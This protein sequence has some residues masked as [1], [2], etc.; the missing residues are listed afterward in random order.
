[1][2]GSPAITCTTP[3]NLFPEGFYDVIDNPNDDHSGFAACGDHTGGGNML[4]VNGSGTPNFDVWCQTVPV[5]PNTLYVFSAWVTTVVSSAPAVLQFSINGATIGPTFNAPNQNCIW[6]NYFRTWNSGPSTSATICIV[7]QNTAQSGNDF[8]LDDIVF[9]PTCSV[10]D[11]VTVNVVS[12]A[13][14]ASP[15]LVNIPCAGAQVTLNGNGSSAGP[16]V[17]Y[18][19]DTANGHIVSGETT[20]QPVV[21]EVGA[22][23]LHVY[24]ETPDGTICEKNVTVNVVPGPPFNTWINPPLPL[25]CGSPSV[26]LVGNASQLPNTTFQWSTFDGSIVSGDDTRFCTINQPGTYSVV[27]TNVVTGCTAEAQVEVFSNDNLPTAIASSSGTI[28]C[29]QNAVP[30][31]ALGSTTGPGISY[32]W[33]TLNGSIV[34]SPFGFNTT[35]GAAGTYILRVTNAANCSVTDTIVVA[36]NTTPPTVV[37]TFPPQLSC[38]PNQDTIS[39]LIYA[40]PPPFVLINWTTASGNIV[41]GQ[42]T[43]NPQVSQPGTYAVSVFDPNNGC[44]TYDTSL[45]NANFTIP[46]ASILPP[47]TVTCQSPT[48]ALSGNG[49]STGAGVIFQWQAS[50]GGNIVSGGNTLSPNVNAAGNYALIVTDSLSQCRDTAFVSV[51]ADTSVVSAVANAPDTLNC[52]TNSVIL[53]A[54]GSSAGTN[55]AYNWTTTNGTISAGANTANPT[56]S[57]PGTYQLLV[58]NTTNGCTATDLAIVAQNTNPPQF[59]IA[60]PPQITCANPTQTLSAQNNGPSGNYTYNWTASN[61]GN[62]V[63]GENTLTPLVS[64]AGIYTLSVTNLSDGC[65]ATVN[66]SVSAEAGLPSA[67]A[68]SPGPLTCTQTA[69]LLQSTG[70]SLGPNFTYQWSTLDG[71][72][73]QN[74]NSPSPTVTQAGSYNLLITNTL[75]GCSAADTVTVVQDIAPPIADAG[76]GDTLTC[77]QPN[78]NLLAIKNGPQDS[79]YFEWATIGGHYTSQPDAAFLVV[80]SAGLF[81]LEVTNLNNGCTATDTVEVWVNQQPPVLSVA[82]PMTLTCTTTAVTL[83]AAATGTDLSFDWETATGQ[84]VSGQATAAPTVNLPGNYALT[85]TD[86]TNGCS[87]TGGVIVFQNTIA[88][89]LSVVAP[90]NLNCNVVTQTIQAQNL[91]TAGNFNYTWTASNGGNI[92]SGSNTLSPIVSAGGDFSLLALNTI[93]GCRD[94]LSVSVAQDTLSPMADAGAS[95]TLDCNVN[96]LTING[97]GAGAP[98]LSFEWSAS[99]GGNITS[100]ANTLTPTVNASG[101]YTLTVSNPNNGCVAA[102]SVQIFANAAAPQASIAAPA[103]ITCLLPQTTLSASASSG[104]AFEY[105]WSAS[106]NGNIVSGQNTL[107][108]TVDSAG[109]YT[110]TVSNTANGCSTNAS[111]TANLALPNVSAGANQTITCSQSNIFL[112]GTASPGTT[113][114]W[115]TSDGNIV[116]GAAT[117][118]PLVNQPGIYTLSAALANNGCA[119]SDFVQIGI[120]TL[121]PTATVAMPDTLT[122]AVESVSLIAAVQQPNAAN[123]NI[124]WATNSGHFVS[125]QNTLNPVVDSIGY[126]FLTLTNTLNGCETEIEVPVNQNV[127]APVALAAPN[128][129]ITCTNLSATLSG[130]GSDAGNYAWAASNGGQ[131]ASGANTL[132]PSVTAAGLYTLTVTNPTNGCSAT[133]TATVSS[134]TAPPNAV[135]ATPETLTCTQ[136]IV[137]LN[138]SASSQGPGFNISWSTLDGHLLPIQNFLMPSADQPGT[139]VLSIQN[140]QNG[141]TQSAQVLVNQNTTPPS[142][143]AGPAQTLH[144][145]QPEAALLGSSNTPGNPTFA[146]ATS[147]GHIVGSAVGASP[148]VDAEGLYTLTVTHP[149][150]GCTATD[151]VRVRAVPPPAFLPTLRQ[152]DCLT[153]V[154]AVDFGEVLGGQSPFQY[155]TDGGVSFRTAPTFANLSPGD[156]ELVVRDAYGCTTLENATLDSPTLP[157]LSLPAV[158]NLQLGDSTQLQPLTNL[159]PDEVVSW[160]WSPAT[161][162]SCTDCPTPWATPLRGTVYTLT[163]SDLSGCEAQAKIQLRVDRTRN[164]YAPNVFSPNSDNE[165]DRFLIFGKGVVDVRS[166]MVFDRWGTQVFG[167]THFPINDESAGWDGTFRGNLLNPAVFVWVAEIE[168][169]D[170]AVELFSGDVTL[171]R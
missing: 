103:T 106:A 40:G 91:A 161:G 38:N 136:T 81:V 142:A 79:L 74:P 130:A 43:P 34:G 113:L 64:A 36:G 143:E 121:H 95:N 139:Y 146:W 124:A 58:S 93:N 115:Q 158:L 46:M 100:G 24:Y 156:Y 108:P 107:T 31:S 1:M 126:Y 112:A 159:Q 119:A 32:A 154:G 135:I 54:L 166:L 68:A 16:N 69:L 19:W 29:V 160:Q 171:L 33:S 3:G 65:T 9:A 123:L 96:N 86:G 18:L 60:P 49:S 82:F 131:I 163:I 169:V 13:A 83:S 134:N 7:N 170:G 53:N 111:V 72:I 116:S 21:D 76:I 26:T 150:N 73:S 127:V 22:Y 11:Q 30:L 35:A 51:L 4:V 94:S 109:V 149:T 59:Q 77:S 125:G 155:S 117:L 14:V 120:D 98:A 75:N 61:G 42:Y 15:A 70:S 52:A 66:A 28:T 162:L 90:G 152:P 132:N 56:A 137:V 138:A 37:G 129:Q 105:N 168:F 88:P 17:T 151:T 8:A 89:D 157:E 25:G 85:V 87:D 23:T 114:T 55:I 10:Q 147:D 165:N 167:E 50:N 78:V 20:L 97:F 62:I 141:C 39:L 80:D 48:I 41:S 47:D 92:A 45:V 145:N 84:F 102:D 140:L 5:T 57:A 110:L 44:Y 104:P 144:C 6:Q 71:N 148:D 12:V 2:L 67:L 118:T 63:N 27:A 122:C 164:V 133:A 128:G 101:I 153:P 99:S